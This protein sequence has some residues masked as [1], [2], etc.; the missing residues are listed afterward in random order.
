MLK[1]TY[2][3]QPVGNTAAASGLGQM[4]IRKAATRCAA[5]AVKTELVSSPAQRD[6]VS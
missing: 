6:Y 4:R 5:E 2:L 3:G 1:E